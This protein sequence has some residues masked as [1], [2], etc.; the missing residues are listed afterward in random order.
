V[1]GEL[2]RKL[3]AIV[4]DGVTSRTHL[5]V[6]IVPVDPPAAGRGT[7]SIGLS[8]LALDPGF[9][10]SLVAF[11][12]TPANPTS[13]RVLPLT[14]KAELSFSMQPS[15][16]TETARGDARALMLEDIAAVAHLLADTALGSGSGFAIA[17][18]DPGFSVQ[19]FA[20]DKGSV[21]QDLQ[22]G[23][24]T[25]RLDY[26]GRA[27]VWPVGVQGDEGVI[28][29]AD[30]LIVPL[31]LALRVTDGGV[32]PG[33]STTIMVDAPQT[34]RLAG[35]AGGSRA[36]VRLAVM[37]LADVPPGQRGTIPTGT[38]GAE[39]G[40]RILEVTGLHLAVQY[41]APAGNPG[42]AGRIEH[43]AV[44]LATSSNTSGVLLGSVAI[45]LLGS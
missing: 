44:H 31:P 39:T 22:A 14:F 28:R 10:P 2:E 16:D 37:V 4:A 8:D 42:P 30:P 43:V 29:A 41:Q 26:L 38:A 12:G 7:I 34:Q 33:G 17:S 24:Y 3:A 35:P 25:G 9:S 11:G 13:R 27:E 32:Q 19:A 23:H 15:A 1:L 6:G 5:T 21:Q 45:R 40:V 18:P 36:P 20:L